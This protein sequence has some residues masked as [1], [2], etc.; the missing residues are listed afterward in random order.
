MQILFQQVLCLSPT[1]S[2]ILLLHGPQ[3][4]QIKQYRNTYQNGSQWL[5]TNPICN[6]VYSFSLLIKTHN[7]QNF[8]EEEI[9]LMARSVLNLHPFSCLLSLLNKESTSHFLGKLWK[10][11][12]LY[13]GREVL[14]FLKPVLNQTSPLTFPLNLISLIRLPLNQKTNPSNLITRPHQDYSCYFHC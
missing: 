5:V 8:Q 10:V 4:E 14:F 1:R 13:F 12:V 11:Q 7:L 6:I 9:S 2:P 3:L